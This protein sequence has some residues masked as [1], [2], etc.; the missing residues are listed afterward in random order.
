MGNQSFSNVWDAIEGSP[1]DA[2]RMKL[3]SAGMRE[4]NDLLSDTNLTRHEVAQLLGTTQERIDELRHGRMNLFDVHELAT[5]T[6]VARR[7]LNS[8]NVPAV[9]PSGAKNKFVKK[10]RTNF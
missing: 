1:E 5:M 2:H 8:G 7:H 4:L 3:L 9:G 10:P 6:E